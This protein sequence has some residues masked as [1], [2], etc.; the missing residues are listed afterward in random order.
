MP[1][2]EHAL[3]RG[4]QGSGSPGPLPYHLREAAKAGEN[5]GLTEFFYSP[6]PVSAGLQKVF[7][8]SPDNE[9]LLKSTIKKPEP[10]DVSFGFTPIIQG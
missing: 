2:H 5:R 10:D 6:R 3:Y 8:L 4:D 7:I 1:D 9:N